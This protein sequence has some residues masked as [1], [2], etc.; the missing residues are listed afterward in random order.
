[1]TI[2]RLKKAVHVFHVALFSI[3]KAMRC[4][5]LVLF[6]AESLASRNGCRKFATIVH[7]PSRI[8]FTFCSEYHSATA[9]KRGQYSVKIYI[10]AVSMHAVGLQSYR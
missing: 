8:I 7:D 1:M 2:L 3:A 9:A 5:F 4:I 6:I 10:L